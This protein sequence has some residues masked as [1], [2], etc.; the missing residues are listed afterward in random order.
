ME[1]D[2][3]HEDNL[4]DAMYEDPDDIYPEINRSFRRRFNNPDMATC[5][6]NACLQ[7]ILIAMDH[8]DNINL[9]SE[10]GLELKH[11]TRIYP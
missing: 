2:N 8:G 11:L 10:L 9:D 6:L 7:L 4:N 1:N 5:W 3:L